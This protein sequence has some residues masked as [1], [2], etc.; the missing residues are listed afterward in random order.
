MYAYFARLS[1]E[2]ESFHSDEIADVEQTL[3]YVVVQSLVFVRTDVVAGDV[4]LYASF[5]VLYSAKLALPITRRL[6]SRPATTTL[7]FSS[8]L[9]LALMSSE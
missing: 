5:R 7:R 8:S 6:I 3:E 9:K 2:D 4:Y 1:L